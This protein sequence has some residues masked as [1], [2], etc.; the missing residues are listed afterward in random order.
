MRFSAHLQNNFVYSCCCCCFLK[1]LKMYGTGL[2]KLLNYVPILFQHK[3][4]TSLNKKS[5]KLVDHQ[6]PKLQINFGRINKV[7]FI[8]FFHVT[9]YGC[10]LLIKSQ[11]AILLLW[12]T[13]F[14]SWCSALS[15][16][17]VSPHPSLNAP[18]LGNALIG[19]NSASGTLCQHV[20]VLSAVDAAGAPVCMCVSVTE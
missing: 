19:L 15:F 13:R 4:I 10:S 12:M 7:F 2:F 11:S 6:I 1:W 9:Y 8:L 18:Y 3:I 5:I 20:S 14:P 16:S 17:P